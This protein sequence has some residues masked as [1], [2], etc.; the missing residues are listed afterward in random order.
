MKKQPHLRIIGTIIDRTKPVTIGY[1]IYD[2]STKTV[3]MQTLNDILAK[4]N[5]LENATLKNGVLRGTECKLERLPKY[6]VTRKKLTQE[7]HVA[8]RQ[9]IYRDA[10]MGYALLDLRDFTVKTAHVQELGPLITSKAI[11]NLSLNKQNKAVSFMCAL[12]K[13]IVG[14][15]STKGKCTAEQYEI[16]TRGN[17]GYDSALGEVYK[18]E[19]YTLGDF[20]QTLIYCQKGTVSIHIE[21]TEQELF[22]IDSL[23]QKV[24]K[25]YSLADTVVFPE[26]TYI[27]SLE[28]YSSEVHIKFNNAAMN[29]RYQLEI[30]RDID[31][32]AREDMETYEKTYKHI[33]LCYDK[34]STHG[35]RACI[36]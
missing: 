16:C 11:P 36:I 30:E 17:K 35:V 10:L 29:Y 4:V 34:P 8:I 21:D 20:I 22:C 2:M 19:V 5:D 32:L 3:T 6:D 13:V 9:L 28:L 1:V 25:G 12:P 7:T 18:Y 27:S 24:L 26:L 23:S 33:R 31:A 15:D 14:G